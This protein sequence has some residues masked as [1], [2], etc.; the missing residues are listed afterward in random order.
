MY[1]CACVCVR[2]K[3][4][5]TTLCNCTVATG[6][7]EVCYPGPGVSMAVIF[8]VAAE[9]TGFILHW[10]DSRSGDPDQG[11]ALHW[12]ALC[13][14]T[15]R[16]NPLLI[17]F[18]GWDPWTV[19]VKKQF[20]TDF[21]DAAFSPRWS[22]TEDNPTC[23]CEPSLFSVSFTRCLLLMWEFQT[24]FI[25]CVLGTDFLEE[26]WEGPQGKTLKPA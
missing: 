19:T 1:A 23:L 20:H 21:L 6:R 26:I 7:I 25:K 2:L 3:V 8:T 9:V 18:C 10:C 22:L 24:K 4:W 17:I 13:L 14:A 15:P 11:H 12:R 5:N 16:K